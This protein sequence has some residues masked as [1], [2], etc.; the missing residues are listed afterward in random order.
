MEISTDILK[1]LRDKT[2]VSV[3][4]CKKALE[5]AEGD[6]DKAKVIL[7]KQS[8]VAASKKG[9]RTLGAGIIAS[10]LHNTSRVGSMVELCSETDFVAVALAQ[11]LARVLKD[12]ALEFRAARSTGEGWNR[13]L[14]GAGNEAPQAD[15]EIVTDK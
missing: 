4:Q 11:S 14:A 9:G 1:Q 7:Q 15:D 2:G 10:Y 3:M 6:V 12:P 5:E 13:F 8:A